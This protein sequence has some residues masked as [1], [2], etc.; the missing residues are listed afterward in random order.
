M[1]VLLNAPA[2][3]GGQYCQAVEAIDSPL[4]L[5]AVADLAE[6]DGFYSDDVLEDIRNFIRA[7]VV[8]VRRNPEKFE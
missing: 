6:C 2:Y 3:I 4:D 7:T 1:K 8:F 5:A